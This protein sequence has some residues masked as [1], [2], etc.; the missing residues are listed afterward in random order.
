MMWLPS[1]DPSFF[2]PHFLS[3]FFLPPQTFG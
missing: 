1:V 2:P 3:L